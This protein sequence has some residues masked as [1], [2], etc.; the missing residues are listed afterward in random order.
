MKLFENRLLENDGEK[1]KIKRTNCFGL[2]ETHHEPTDRDP[3]IYNSLVIRVEK[4]VE[5]IL[6]GQLTKSKTL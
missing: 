3:T 4:P 2:Q 5:Q 1:N 6:E